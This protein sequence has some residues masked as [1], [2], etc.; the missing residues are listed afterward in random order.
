MLETRNRG[1]WIPGGAIDAGENFMQ[2]AK[3]ECLEEAGIDVDLKG[4]LRVDYGVQGDQARMRAIFYAEPSTPE[5]ARSL[6][7]VADSESVMAKWVTL[8]EA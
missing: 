2:G 8:D 6:K 7:T 3:R 1:W 4:I 5:Q